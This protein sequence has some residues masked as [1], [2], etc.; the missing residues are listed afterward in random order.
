[1]GSPMGDSLQNGYIRGGLAVGAGALGLHGGLAAGRALANK[2]GAEDDDHRPD[3]A[4]I[5][6][7]ELARHKKLTG[8]FKDYL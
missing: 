4:D 2:A 3:L 7:L 8:P 5:D 1:M 6:L